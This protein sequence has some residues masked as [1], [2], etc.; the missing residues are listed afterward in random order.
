MVKGIHW[1]V[2]RLTFFKSILKN[3]NGI[4]GNPLILVLRTRRCSCLDLSLLELVELLL[5]WCCNLILV[6]GNADS[7]G[8]HSGFIQERRMGRGVEKAASSLVLAIHGVWTFYSHIV[9]R[10]DTKEELKFMFLA[11]LSSLMF[12]AKVEMKCRGNP[13]LCGLALRVVFLLISI[14]NWYCLSYRGESLASPEHWSITCANATNRAFLK[15]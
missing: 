6:L 2:K 10:V 9:C 3:Q 1:F 13:D 12:L 4:E 15:S 11:G 8:W 7:Q 14:L 5:M